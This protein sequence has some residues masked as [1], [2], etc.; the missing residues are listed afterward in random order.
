MG[1]IKGNFLV[2]NLHDQTYLH[3]YS[4]L[5]AICFTIYPN[6]YDK[7]DIGSIIQEELATLQQIIA[8]YFQISRR[9]IE[10]NGS[11]FV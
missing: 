11:L 5:L 6:K 9:A 7:L 3:F 8:W 4:G 10:R 2:R 1:H